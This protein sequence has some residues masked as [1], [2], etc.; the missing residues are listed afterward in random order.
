[1]TEGSG[2]GEPTTWD[3]IPLL[4]YESEIFIR[5]GAWKSIV[6][7]E[8]HLTLDEMFLLYRACMN[9]N[10]NQMKMLAAAQGADVDFNDDWYDPEP[11]EVVDAYNI[12]AIPFG[13]GY[14][15]I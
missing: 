12:N 4:K 6:E 2:S 3:D 13:L 1:M 10:S 5:T 14:E 15:E 9:E 11:P 7:L 8:E